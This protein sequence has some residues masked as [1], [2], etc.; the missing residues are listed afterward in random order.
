MKNNLYERDFTQWLSQ[1]RELLASKR[2][3]ELDLDNLLEALE[4]EVGSEIGR[5]ESYLERLIKHL[6][7][8]SYQ[9]QVLQDPW[10]D[11]MLSGWSD[12][13]D[14]SRIQINRFINKK[15]SLQTTLEAMLE[16]VYSDS[17]K[18][19]I[20]EMNKFARTDNQRLDNNSFPN[21]CPWSF[22]Q[23]MIVSW[24]PLN[25]VEMDT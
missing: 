24:Y 25:G 9:K 11:Y 21:K 8:Y 20:I 3:D 18:N 22:E 12:S 7:K 4:Y 13:I 19:A 15:P 1:Q 5:L 6:L 10:V 14:D 16:E 2:F 17:K 23:I